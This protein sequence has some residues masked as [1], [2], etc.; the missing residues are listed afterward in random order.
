MVAYTMFVAFFD[1]SIGVISQEALVT[2]CA[3]GIGMALPATM[4]VIQASVP[5]HDMAAATSGWVLIR[6]LG[7]STGK[8]ALFAPGYPGYQV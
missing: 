4:L 8:S 2:L 6:S 7:P 1:S 3:G 5:A